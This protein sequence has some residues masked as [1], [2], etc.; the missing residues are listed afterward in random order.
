MSSPLLDKSG[1]RFWLPTRDPNGIIIAMTCVNP[2]A[3]SFFISGELMRE[4]LIWCVACHVATIACAATSSAQ[5]FPSKPIHIITAEPGGSVDFAARIVSQGLPNLID[6]QVIVEN[7]GGASGAIAAARVAKAPPDGYTLLF[8]GNPFW[9]LPFLRDGVPYDPI[10]DFAPITLAT[11]SPNVIAVVSSLPVNS[12]KEMIS[13]AKTQQGALNYSSGATGAIT[14]I[15][16]ELFNSMAGLK[17]VRIPYKGAGLALNALI[18]GEVQLMFPTLGQVMPHV[19][20][21]RL[22]ALAITSAQPSPLAPDWPTVSASGLPGFESVSMFGVF[23]PIKTPAAIINRLSQD[24]ASVVTQSANKEKLF[25]T[26]VEPVGNSPAEFAR[27]I[28]TE[29]T[30]LG[31][32]I[33]D[34]GIRE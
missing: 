32:V 4:V 7:Q 15:A 22:K 1:A 3:Y 14:H 27:L 31:K 2:C 21:G 16:A 20:S 24:I 25:G 29:M 9:L 8:Y 18:A 13:L 11:R 34:A 28:R 30:I 26:G 12:V 33:K 23:A 10:K 6:Q 5:D 17:L 19:K